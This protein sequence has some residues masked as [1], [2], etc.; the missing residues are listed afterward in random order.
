MIT[1]GIKK[2]FDYM[3]SDIEKM[4]KMEII[5]GKQNDNGNKYFP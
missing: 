2:Y 1:D 4:V 5:N 3:A